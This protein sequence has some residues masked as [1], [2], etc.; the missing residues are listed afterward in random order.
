MKKNKHFSK[1]VE[2][3][4]NSFNTYINNSFNKNY[5]TKRT[6]RIT[7][8]NSSSFILVQDK[9]KYI[10]EKNFTQQIPS[11][12]FLEEMYIKYSKNLQKYFLKNQT[13]LKL[14]G[15]KF[16]QNLTIE[17][18]M[19]QNNLTKK[20]FIQLLNGGIPLENNTNFEN[21]NNEQLFL[22]P[23]P[24]KSRQLLNTNKE[25][26]DFLEAERSAV[27]MRTFEYTHGI[28]SKVGIYEYKKLMMEQKQR[29]INLMLN[30]AKKIQRWWKKKSYVMNNNKFDENLNN[31]LLIYGDILSRKK[32]KNFYDKMY[33]YVKFLLKPKRKNF[34][35]KLKNKAKHS[36]RKFYSIFDWNKNMKKCNEIKLQVIDDHYLYFVRKKD[37]TINK[38]YG[39]IHN[40]FI[41]KK[42]FISKKTD[43]FGINTE[44]YQLKQ[45]ILIQKIFRHFLKYKK[46]KETIRE[47]YNTQFS[48]IN[49]NKI[50]FLFNKNANSEVKNSKSYSKNKTKND[51]ISKN[52]DNKQENKSFIE[53]K[54]IIGNLPSISPLS[55]NQDTNDDIDNENNTK[56]DLLNKKEIISNIKKKLNDIKDI[57]DKNNPITKINLNNIKSN[58]KKKS[59]NKDKLK[60]VNNGNYNKNN[61]VGRNNDL[62][63][64][65]KNS[66]REIKNS[67]NNK[68][69]SKKLNKNYQPNRNNIID[70]YLNNQ[71]KDISK[72]ISPDK[73]NKKTSNIQYSLPI[74]NNIN[75]YPIK[76]KIDSKKKKIKNN[77]PYVSK[78]IQKSI[79]NNS[80]FNFNSSLYAN[81]QISFGVDNAPSE[82]VKKSFFDNDNINNNSSLNNYYNLNNDNEDSNY[83]INKKDNNNNKIQ[84]LKYLPQKKSYINNELGFKENELSFINKKNNAQN[85]NIILV[86]SLEIDNN[87][88]NDKKTIKDINSNENFEK[89]LPPDINLNNY[90]QDSTIDYRDKKNKSNQKSISG[91]GILYLDTSNN[92]INNE[93]NDNFQLL[94]QI[95]LN[96]IHRP[97]IIGDSYIYKI[98][99]KFFSTNFNKCMNSLINIKNSFSFDKLLHNHNINKINIL[100]KYINH[101]KY[102]AIKD[103]EPYTYSKTIK[104][105]C[106]AENN[107]KGEHFTY[108]CK[109]NKSNHEND[110]VFLRISLGYKLLRKVFC[111]ND[112]KIFFY[113]LKK[114]RY[115]RKYKAKTYIYKRSSSNIFNLLYF[116]IKLPTLLIKIMIKK[117][118]SIFYHKFLYFSLNIN[119]NIDN[120][121]DNNNVCSLVREGYGKGYFG[122]LYNILKERYN[123]EYINSG[124]KFESFINILFS[125][126]E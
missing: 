101:W 38:N 68:K 49:P 50:L 64:Y 17:E 98:R 91:S 112:L 30:A 82:I 58:S 32:A 124:L 52:N 88:K 53:D 83:N 5:D 123:Y 126:H 2:N 35:K 46:G 6:P 117:Y 45:I 116:K 40:F 79:N 27:V 1:S 11:S 109:I 20:Q 94:G 70:K 36:K 75:T 62:N 104:S 95:G 110:F 125:L 54:K 107:E 61:I 16:F 78:N 43:N 93:Q 80:E 56:N 121:L 57:C 103:S 59:E 44:N 37:L 118:C 92:K 96:Y 9:S 120:K 7:T 22:T 72:N 4:N 47:G 60:N 41:S 24:N 55:K 31:R 89:S 65:K 48:Y 106:P 69:D 86:D 13:G 115:R 119:N 90:Q 105:I 122:M 18:Y 100:R 14:S 73:S 26:S 28:K 102:M 42:Y 33:N 12:N 76:N 84:T 77:L 97:C 8:K 111:G 66:K 114:R 87:K 39:F 113:L 63:I 21:I 19:K 23:L 25:K 71:I 3:I 15:N 74:K 10:V 34:I 29:L 67:K 51:Y 99:K 81:K 85:K 108:Y